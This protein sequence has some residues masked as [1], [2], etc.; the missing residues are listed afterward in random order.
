L[1]L[2]KGGY[3]WV[4]VISEERADGHHA[5]GGEE[6]NQDLELAFEKDI[7]EIS[8][9]SP[10]GKLAVHGLPFQ[11]VDDYSFRNALAE[12]VLTIMSKGRDLLLKNGH[13]P[14]PGSLSTV[15]ITPFNTIRACEHVETPQRTLALLPRPFMSTGVICS[16]SASQSNY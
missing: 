9:K 13:T 4:F 16:S 14:S 7:Q 15:C 5:D 3:F 12:P 1:F 10:V 6:K 2:E 11:S 8:E